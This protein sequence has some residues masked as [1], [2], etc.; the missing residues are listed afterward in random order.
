MFER[1]P[2][3]RLVIQGPG[4]STGNANRAPFRANRDNRARR[5]KYTP[6]APIA[7][8]T[9]IGNRSYDVVHFRPGEG[10]EIDAGAIR[11]PVS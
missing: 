3:Y 8:D 10:V 9:D 1:T 11:V 2:R 4:G 7:D 5:R 6:L